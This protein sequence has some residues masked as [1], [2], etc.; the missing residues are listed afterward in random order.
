MKRKKPSVQHGEKQSQELSQEPSARGPG[1]KEE[2]AEF[3]DTWRKL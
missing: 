1:T 3:L 2:A